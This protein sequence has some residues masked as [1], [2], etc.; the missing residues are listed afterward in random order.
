MAVN[1]APVFVALTQA[2][3]D[4]AG[5]L[6]AAMPGSA[7]HG[8]ARRADGTDLVFDDTV[9]HL[10]WLFA[11]GRPIVGLCAAGILI[12]AL[13]PLLGD[14]REEPPVLALAED[15][16][17]VVP[18][19]GGHRGANALARAIADRLGIAPSVTT[20]GDARFGVALDEPPSGWTLANPDDAKSVMA[21]LLDGERLRVEGSI[22]WLSESDLPLADDG[23]KR[24]VA[25]EAARAG[26]A[27][28]LVYHPAVLAVG[29]GCE[30]G[31][32]ASELI[33]LVNV[34]LSDA[35][36]SPKA[37]AAVVSLDLKEDEAAVH[38]VADMLEVAPRFFDAETLEAQTPRLTAP[39]E[40]VFR[41]VG[42]HG[43]AEAAALA[44]AGS[45]GELVVA[46]RKSARA[47]C[48][49]ARAPAVLDARAI[50]RAHGRLE[51][52]GLG[53]GQASWR[54][55]QA[56]VVLAACDDVVGYSGYLDLISE[57]SGQVRHA[58]GLG[59][60]R[61]RV[62]HALDL[63]ARGRHV[64]LV[65]SGDAGVYAMA[66]L[67]FEM[68][69]AAAA[70]GWSRVAIEVVPGITAMQ[71]AAAR[72]G[73]PL[74]HD[75]CA[76]SLSDLMTPWPVIERRIEAAAAGDFVT[77]F[78]NPVSLRRRMQLPA[79]RTILLRHRPPTTPVVLARNLGRDGEQ[80]RV[81]DLASLH[82]DEVDMLTLV[83]VGS[84]QTV[85]MPR[86]DGRTAVY[87]PRGYDTAPRSARVGAESA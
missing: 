16:S 7:L 15:G 85:A 56:D 64:A 67:A 81:T 73:A 44:A 41:E 61:D 55:P 49:I 78:Y 36:L 42:C 19:L 58:F 28:A 22:P 59:E 4:L 45:D 60:E 57:R 68:V 65:C 82:V 84:S 17:A 66:S 69:D 74:G 18:L 53:P 33:D 27:D 46:K 12:R 52:I 86:G 1:D 77:A 30:R 10:R 11:A 48:A 24:A 63:A 43:V 25:T 21:S 70:P 6:R 37:V 75:F 2:G 23:A 47:T 87:T 32:D 9:A 13:A 29:V 51:L 20:A 26:D 50:G 14:K 40:V 38:A 72:I 8:R 80:V 71:A 34:C 54:C 31:T 5:G 83:L 39:S 35:G 79:A 3:A 62:A 76:I